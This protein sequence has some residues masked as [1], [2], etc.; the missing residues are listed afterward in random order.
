MLLL[1]TRVVYDFFAINIMS[2][3]VMFAD[4]TATLHSGQNLE[5]LI[6]KVEND[7]QVICEWL[8]NNS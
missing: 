7:M 8:K 5:E 2:A 1:K 3:L 4:D 6:R